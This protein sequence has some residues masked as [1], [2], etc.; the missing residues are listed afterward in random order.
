MDH[1][2][3]VFTFAYKTLNILFVHLNNNNSWRMMTITITVLK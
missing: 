3:Y 2:V 1:G